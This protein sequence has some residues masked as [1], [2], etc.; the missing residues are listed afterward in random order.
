MVAMEMSETL[1][2]YHWMTTMMMMMVLM[3]SRQTNYNGGSHRQHGTAGKREREKTHTHTLQNTENNTHFSRAR[4]IN[5]AQRACSCAEALFRPKRLFQNPAGAVM[6]NQSSVVAVRGL[7]VR[8]CARRV[9]ANT[10]LA[11]ELLYG[12]YLL[13]IL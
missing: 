4:Q 12:L 3:M 8:G 11:R 5:M 9:R 1:A 7:R 2:D 6:V 13:M 10:K